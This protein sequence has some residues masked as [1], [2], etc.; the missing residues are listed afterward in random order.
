MAAFSEQVFSGLPAEIGIVSRRATEDSLG[1]VSGQISE[2][3][4]LDDTVQRATE[5]QSLQLQIKPSETQ[6]EE[7]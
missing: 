6:I 4:E 7:N 5:H 3:A 2:L 1:M